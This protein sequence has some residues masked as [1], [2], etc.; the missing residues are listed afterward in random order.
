MIYFPTL[1]KYMEDRI[2]DVG[3][4]STERRDILD[5]WA[6][7][8]VEMKSAQEKVNVT[9]ICTHNSRRS[10]L[11]QAWSWAASRY[12][13]QKIV[14]SYSAGT[15]VTACH[16]NTI[17]ALE[18]A[19]IGVQRGEGEN[20]HYLVRLNDEFCSMKLFSK[21]FGD[22]ENPTENFIALMT[23]SDA[24]ENCP[25]VPGASHRISLNYDD[26]KVS[27]GTPAQESTYDECCRQIA[28]EMMYAFSRMSDL[29]KH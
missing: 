11:A 12:Y 15:E 4:I 19:G 26:P 29:L 13:G 7:M 5:H 22:D 27:D 9:F 24:E 16:P 14:K 1:K 10:Q 2:A 23:C 21:T 17:A 20:P 18:R 6:Q 25:Y 8:M 3:S 28:T